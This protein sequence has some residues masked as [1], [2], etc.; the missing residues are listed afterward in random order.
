VLIREVLV[1]RHSYHVRM[2]QKL[3]ILE[4]LLKLIEL[5]L[6][7]TWILLLHHMLLSHTQLV[8]CL[9]IIELWSCL[10][11]LRWPSHREL[12]LEEMLI[13]HILACQPLFNFLIICNTS[14]RA[15]IRHWAL[16]FSSRRLLINAV[17]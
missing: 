1:V 17:F 4:G 14:T 5:R 7:L 3:H 8:S 10:L 12:R 16:E 6:V 13:L 15:L 11:L 9:I 2:L